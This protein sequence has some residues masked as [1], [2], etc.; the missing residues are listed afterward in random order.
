MSTFSASARET[1]SRRMR[2]GTTARA[3]S[4]SEVSQFDNLVEENTFTG[5]NVGILL[6]GATNSA[7]TENIISASIVAGIRVNVIATGNLIEENTSCR[8]RPAST[9]S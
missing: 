8:I 6:F 2:S 5:N 4:C 3:A 9:S 7:V 1:P